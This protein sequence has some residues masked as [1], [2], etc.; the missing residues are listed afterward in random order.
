MQTKKIIFKLGL[1]LIEYEEKANLLLINVF[2]NLQMF[3][4]HV[5]N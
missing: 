4:R 5:E 1:I 2:K 3:T